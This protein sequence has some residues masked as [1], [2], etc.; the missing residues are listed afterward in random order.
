MQG[1]E[2]AML[3]CH[4]GFNVNTILLDGAED[5]ISTELLKEVTGHAPWS[6]SH[7]PNWVKADIKYPVGIVIEP[8]EGI[9]KTPSVTALHSQCSPLSQPLADSSPASRGASEQSNDD[10]DDAA[11]VGIEKNWIAT[12]SAKPRNDGLFAVYIKEHC[13]FLKILVDKESAS[14][15]VSNDVKKQIIIL[16]ENSLKL[17][18]LFEKI[19]SETVAL[20]AAK[21]LD[22]DISYHFEGD[23]SKIDYLSKLEEAF[24]KEGMEKTSFRAEDAPQIKGLGEMLR[25]SETEGAAHEVSVGVAIQNNQL[26]NIKAKVIIAK[27]DKELEIIFESDEAD[28]KPNEN[29]IFVSKHKNGLVLI[30]NIE[31]R[32]LPDFSCQSCF[33]RLVTYIKTEL[34][35]R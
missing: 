25:V 8:T 20:T 18:S 1:I 35:R 7:K 5:Q 12:A 22:G 11:N 14:N 28:I 34:S 31:T 26:D 15:Q 17:R 9:Q 21:A 19:F 29:T 3:F 16:P 10:A 13:G 30:D 6:N 2:L 32:L 24:A 33:T 27:G 4:A 23:F